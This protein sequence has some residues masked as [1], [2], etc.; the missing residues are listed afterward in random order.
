MIL[1]LCSNCLEPFLADPNYTVKPL[2]QTIPLKDRE[3]HDSDCFI[4]SR[5]GRDYDIEKAR[6]GRVAGRE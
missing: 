6:N 5:Q 3:K 2:R 4:C 1:T